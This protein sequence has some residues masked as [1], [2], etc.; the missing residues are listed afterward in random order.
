[1]N[2]NSADWTFNVAIVGATKTGKTALLKA[3]MEQTFDSKYRQ[4]LGSEHGKIIGT[5]QGETVCL[6]VSSLSG[7][8]RL[9]PL[10]QQHLYN[11]HAVIVTYAINN[12]ASFKQTQFW[13]N[14]ASRSSPGCLIFLVG[15]CTDLVSNA[16][17]RAVQGADA[18]MQAKAW[19]A[20]HYSCSSAK[21]DNIG[22]FRSQIMQQ[23]LKYKGHKSK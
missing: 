6:S 20:R 12:V 17:L 23:L 13:V 16:S 1:M 15:T 9:L 2:Q 21:N 5:S 18:T 3:L 8:S 7:Q 19:N 10:T 14:E 4:T 22:S 11:K